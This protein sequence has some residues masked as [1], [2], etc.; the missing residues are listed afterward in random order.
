MFFVSFVVKECLLFLDGA[1][2]VTPDNG[3]PA[4]G[5]FFQTIGEQ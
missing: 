1:Y 4:T 3:S 2:V 5:H